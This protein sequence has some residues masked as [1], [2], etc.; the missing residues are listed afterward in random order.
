MKCTRCGAE[1]EAQRFCIYCGERLLQSRENL[2]VQRAPSGVMRFR[3]RSTISQSSLPEVQKKG[4]D[5]NSQINLASLNNQSVSCEGNGFSDISQSPV[6]RN[7]S[8]EGEEMKENRKPSLRQS[9]ELEALLL[10]LNHSSEDNAAVLNKKLDEDLAS[11]EEMDD[12]PLQN[13]DVSTDNNE[14]PELGVMYSD[15]ESL[16][17]SFFNSE[18]ADY[19]ASVPVG[20]GSFAR[21]P[22]G[23]F[24]LV[25][26]SIKSACQGM[27]TRM[28][29]LRS[30]T[31]RKNNEPI[32]EYEDGKKQKFIK[33]M[34][35]LAVLVAVI[36]IIVSV[37]S[38]DKTEETT[39]IAAQAPVAGNEDFAILAL[40]EP[41]D[42]S[43]I[44]FGE[45][46][47]A[48]PTL[49]FGESDSEG[50]KI[51]VAANDAAA[52]DIAAGAAAAA[53]N[54]GRLK[55]A[56]LYNRND[57]VMANVSAGESLK[58]N[59]SCIMR[60]GPASR[61]GLVKEIPSGS[62][63]QVLTTTEEDWVLESGG[64]WTKKGQPNK[65]GPGSQFADAQKGMKIPQP[66]SRV[67][68]SNNWRYVQFGKLYGYVGPACFKK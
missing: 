46:D 36:G 58:L 67:I 38:D 27:I 33:L 54:S 28:K 60:E 40:D 11:D 25:I 44:V 37:A 5:S 24:H 23:G 49:E 21:V 14:E 66:K 52:N 34:I 1:V 15:T 16:N 13:I 43:D 51:V 59:K 56:R 48:I 41:D 17:E 61:F 12:S 39:E 2:H 9:R 3:H 62:N 68:S 22:S 18:V 63:I 31:S 42:T 20:S 7:T 45:D 19:S 29:S 53:A 6:M 26:D 8:M 47:F 35:A 30:K 4:P 55:E 57:N 32:S 64:V 50:D 10:K 65:L